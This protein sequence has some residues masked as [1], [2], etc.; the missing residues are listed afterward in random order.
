LYLVPQSQTDKL[1]PLKVEPA[2]DEQLRVLVGRLE[3]ITPEDCQQLVRK[4]VGTDKNPPPE[5]W[6]KEEIKSLGRF[7]EPAIKF[8]ISQTKDSSARERLKVVLSSVRSN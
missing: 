5:Q 7:A 6:A 3:T 1:L 4:L 8:A 2:P